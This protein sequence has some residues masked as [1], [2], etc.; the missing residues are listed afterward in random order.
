M[1]LQLNLQWL[2]HVACHGACHYRSFVRTHPAFH[3]FLEEMEDRSGLCVRK[4]MASQLWIS[5]ELET[6]GRGTSPTLAAID[7]IVYLPKLD[8]VVPP[9]EPAECG[10][11]W[12][13]IL[14]L[15]VRLNLHKLVRN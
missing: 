1:N 3:R 5:I 2:D 12:T 11:F 9:R 7:S 13:G 8:D 4:A 15:V 14:R 6:Q 10:Q